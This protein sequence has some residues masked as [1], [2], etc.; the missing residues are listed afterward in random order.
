[1]NALV[2]LGSGAFWPV[3]AGQDVLDLQHVI[4]VRD[5]ASQLPIAGGEWLVQPWLSTILFAGAWSIGSITALSCLGIALG[6]LLAVQV[7]RIAVSRARP[8]RAWAATAIALIVMMPLMLRTEL[9][10]ALLCATLIV[11]LMQQR[12]WLVTAPL[13]MVAWSN[14]HGSFPIGIAICAAA[15][16]GLM[17]T[18]GVARAR[19]RVKIVWL[20]ACA[21]A[22]VLSPLGWQTWKYVWRVTGAPELARLTPLWQPM[23]LFSIDGLL[24]TAIIV[25]IA[26]ALWRR[27]GGWMR[28][29]PLL[30][31]LVLAGA[32]FDSRRYVTWCVLVALPELAR[33]LDDVALPGRCTV[34]PGFARALLRVSWVG[35]LVVVLMLVPFGPLQQRLAARSL[36]HGGLVDQVRVNDTM[37]ASAEWADYLRLRTGARVVVDARLE[38][39]R[40]ADLVRYERA[41]STG[42]CEQLCDGAATLAVLRVAS[43]DTLMQRLDEAGCMVDEHGHGAAR[44]AVY[45][46]PCRTH[47]ARR[48][49]AG[50]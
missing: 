30:P 5:A 9:V 20:A 33:A 7:W 37:L 48:P 16:G 49:G 2:P 28:C 15:A 39:F 17:A 42:R 35:L 3:L 36:P 19:T 6:G 47:T 32:C 24:I 26:N 50:T 29:A 14:M 45:R 8:G 23:Q 10:A 21:C 1:M 38:R 4:I 11:E 43:A 40:S 34:R 25:L 44:G 18:A 31:I 22:S 41:I 27:P 13:V 12:R 46:L